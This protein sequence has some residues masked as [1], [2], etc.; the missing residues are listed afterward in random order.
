MNYLQ[1]QLFLLV[2]DWA[3]ELALPGMFLFHTLAN[4]LALLYSCCSRLEICPDPSSA[5]DPGFMRIFT[6]RDE[7]L[8]S[9][10]HR[11]S[12]RSSSAVI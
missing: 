12:F 5:T 8:L 6:Y 1:N 2:L 9:V 4:L 3:G 11:Q 10:A 7:D